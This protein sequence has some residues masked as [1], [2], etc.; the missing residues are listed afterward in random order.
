MPAPR[1][2]DDDEQRTWRAFLAA[3]RLVFDELD[4]E[5]QA[6]AGLPH[7]YYV[8]LVA[9][10]ESPGRTLR[11][12]DLA[13][14]TGSSR[15]R[16]SHAVSRLEDAGWV[17]R[18]QCEDDR[19]GTLAALTDAGMAVLTAAAPG[20]V[21]AVRRHFFDRLTPAQV[22]G[23]REACEALLSDRPAARTHAARG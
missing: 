8:V 12:S 14:L 18:R 5:L 11:M 1:W 3:T 15:S 9:L 21:D 22:A 19:R 23:L 10:S 2:L 7:T 6:D 16:L 13:D 4:R 20:H 17:A